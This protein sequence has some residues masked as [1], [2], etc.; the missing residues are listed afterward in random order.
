MLARFIRYAALGA[1]VSAPIGAYAFLLRPWAR[2]WGVDP[3]EAGAVLPGDEIVPDATAVETRGITIAAAPGDVW[4]WLVQ[5][6][7]GRAGFYSYDALDT[8]AGS[9]DSIVPAW[10][11]LAV[12][13]LLPTSPSTGFAVR[14]VEPDHALV[15]Y[16]DHSMMEQRTA[17]T[18]PEDV[19]AGVKASGV[20][21]GRSVPSEFAGTWTFVL[22]PTVDG[23]TRLVERVR[24]QFGAEGRP[25]MAMANGAL[26]F[27][28]FLMIRK[29]L[30]GVRAR[31]ERQAGALQPTSDVTPLAPAPA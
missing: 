10:Q 8:K 17:L 31:A 16:V 18:V 14:V 24:F 25:G 26:G 19:P 29:Q 21:L 20:F 12:G 15:L 1:A 27:G 7:Y 3:A 2:R 23:M 4:P 30:L 6:G 22:T 13:D 11:Q 5:M 28:V 9:A